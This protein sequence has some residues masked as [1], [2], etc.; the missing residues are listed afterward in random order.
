[1]LALIH[2]L[3]MTILMSQVFAYIP[4]TD[5]PWVDPMISSI[6]QEHLNSC[7]SF[8]VN[9]SSNVISL[10]DKSFMKITSNEIRSPQITTNVINLWSSTETAKPLFNK[11]I[12]GKNISYFIM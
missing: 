4:L 3:L 10:Q 9:K 1:M 2:V 12:Q 6:H 8:V 7:S 11:K 5:I